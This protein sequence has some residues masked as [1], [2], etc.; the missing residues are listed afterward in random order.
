MSKSELLVAEQVE[1]ADFSSADICSAKPPAVPEA[2][3]RHRKPPRGRVLQGFHEPPPKSVTVR[4]SAGRPEAAFEAR[5]QAIEA[6][7]AYRRD[8][9]ENQRGGWTAQLCDGLL[10]AV[11]EGRLA[12]FGAT[13]DQ[14]DGRSDKPAYLGPV[15]VALRAILAGNRDPARAD[16]PALDY[17]DA[18]EILLLLERLRDFAAGAIEPLGNRQLPALERFSFVLGTSGPGRADNSSSSEG[19]TV[20]SLGASAP[21]PGDTSKEAFSSPG[22]ATGVSRGR[23]L[24]S[25]RW[26][27]KRGRA[28]VAWGHPGAYALRL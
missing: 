9:G 26:G 24:L 3:K 14:L 17:P 23:A 8:G 27:S 16:D 22:G 7:L 11:K 21:G 25:P 4:D 12:E 15:L 5:R 2:V 13:L 10:G 1:R 28:R 6:Y 18:A 19:A 20:H